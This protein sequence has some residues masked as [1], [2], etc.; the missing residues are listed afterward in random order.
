[1]KRQTLRRSEKWWLAATILCGVPLLSAPFWWRA[2][3]RDVVAAIPSA[4]LPSP[5]AYNDY[6]NATS[7]IRYDHENQWA[8][9]TQFSS[10]LPAL[11]VSPTKDIIIVV[12]GLPNRAPTK[13]RVLNRLYSLS[14]K[15][16]LLRQNAA[17]LQA[18][19]R[20]LKH[21]CAQPSR[22]DSIY[23]ASPPWPKVRQLFNL[24]T[25]QQQFEAQRG[26][27][28]RAVQMAL[29]EMQVAVGLS[30]NASDME[31]AVAR[32]GVAQASTALMKLLPRLNA[33]QTRRALQRLKPLLAR[34]PSY[35]QMLRSE[36]YNVQRSLL[37]EFQNPDWRL[38][39]A[40]GIGYGAPEWQ[41][42]VQIAVLNTVSKQRVFDNYTNF[43]DDAIAR[44]AQPYRN[45]EIDPP[46]PDPISIYLMSAGLR[47]QQTA[48]SHEAKSALSLTS[49]ALQLYQFEHNTLPRQLSELVPRYLKTVPRDPF[50]D[51]QTLRYKPQPLRYISDI[52]QVPVPPTQPNAPPETKPQ[53]EYSNWPYTLYSIGADGKDDGGVPIENTNNTQS[54]NSRYRVDFDKNGDIVAGV[55]TQ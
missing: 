43:M 33:S 20:G 39:I 13:R 15:T 27:T 51:G 6:L 41:Q 47:R 8:T 25:L 55:N 11:P 23:S 21:A 19:A 48:L 37:K 9:E 7:K 32:T 1:M 34:L 30:Q 29:E 3:N 52:R 46:N 54:T 14:E 5:N 31:A 12:D 40:W 42:S 22:D 49:F 10:A 50:F 4:T 24:L 38:R 26:D 44:A 36:K 28:E 18:V 2:F 17:A 53:F 16:W 45:V 35:A